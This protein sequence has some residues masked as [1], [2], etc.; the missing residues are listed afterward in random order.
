MSVEYLIVL[1][2]KKNFFIYFSLFLTL[3]FNKFPKYCMFTN[4]KKICQLIIS[5]LYLQ[6]KS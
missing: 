4:K 3:I 6:N 2:L 1:S 5:N